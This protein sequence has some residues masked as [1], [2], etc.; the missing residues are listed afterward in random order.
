MRVKFEA[1]ERPVTI[2][3]AYGKVTRLSQLKD[4]HTSRI[5]EIDRDLGYLTVP[6]GLVI[7]Q[8]PAGGSKDTPAQTITLVVSKGAP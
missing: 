4:V 5:S 6:K 8:S 2:D 3:E 1:T 7:S